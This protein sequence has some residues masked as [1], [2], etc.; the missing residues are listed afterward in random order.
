[1]SKRGFSGQLNLFDFWGDTNSEDSIVE[2]VSLVPDDLPVFESVKAED[3]LSGESKD[4]E[5]IAAEEETAVDTAFVTEEITVKAKAQVSER[6]SNVEENSIEENFLEQ[7]IKVE[8]KQTP[9]EKKESDKELNVVKEKAPEKK[10]QIEK[11]S[12]ETEASNEENHLVVMHKEVRGKDLSIIAEIS[13]MNYNKVFLKNENYPKGQLFE[14][15]NSKEA[16]DFYITQMML[17]TGEE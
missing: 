11:S 12:K 4:K 6:V 1:M 2:M 7:E 8:N 13:Y 15:D 10:I 17:L 5:N 3:L 9:V 16:V 14:F